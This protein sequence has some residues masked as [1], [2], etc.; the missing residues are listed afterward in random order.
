[1][2]WENILMV[3]KYY[4]DDNGERHYDLEDLHNELDNHIIG[5]IAKHDREGIKINKT[6]LDIIEGVK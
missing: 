6:Y 2:E 1:M 4:K 5:I 3:V